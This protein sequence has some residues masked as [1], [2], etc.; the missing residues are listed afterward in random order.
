MPKM[1]RY[2][3]PLIWFNVRR[4]A[5]LSPSSPAVRARLSG[6]KLRLKSSSWSQR[7]ISSSCHW[8]RSDEAR[9]A[10]YL[11]SWYMSRSPML[12]WS[13]NC[14]ADGR[15]DGREASDERKEDR[16]KLAALGRMINVQHVSFPSFSEDESRRSGKTHF[17]GKRPCPTGLVSMLY[18]KA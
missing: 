11:K 6:M 9:T 18:G 3:C 13:G 2:W 17:L 7:R 1:H 14:R 4:W 15:G 5:S 10:S 12:K 16:S 8:A